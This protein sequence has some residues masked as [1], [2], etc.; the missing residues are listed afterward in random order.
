MIN[1]ITKI[2]IAATVVLLVLWDVYAY[3]AEDNAT[4]SV[5]IT[6]ASYYT[7]WVPFAL[8]VLMG[9][10]FFPAKGSKD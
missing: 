4:I 3:L 1:R 6:D 5:V 2:I 9:H 10:W 7:P 8:G